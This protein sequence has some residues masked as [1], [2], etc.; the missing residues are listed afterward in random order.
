MTVGA[1]LSK[2]LARV[3]GPDV[4][5]FYFTFV[6]SFSKRVSL[7]RGGDVS[8]LTYFTVI[9]ILLQV[10]LQTKYIRNLRLR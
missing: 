1:G 3:R 4:S 2:R 10:F 5:R 7:F 6:I 9:R 8:L